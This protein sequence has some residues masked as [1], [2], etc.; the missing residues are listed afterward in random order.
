MKTKQLSQPLMRRLAG[1]GHENRFAVDGRSRDLLIQIK[2]LLN[3]FAPIGDD[4]R[5]GLWIEVPRGKP[6]DWASFKEVKEWGEEVNTHEEYLEYWKSEFPMDSYWYFLSVSQY[7]GHT[8]LHITDNDHHWCII[9]DDI[10]WDQHG[11]GPVD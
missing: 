4:F 3:V 8:Y 7:N 10:Q 5:H 11:I 6:S 9:H 1:S 2:D